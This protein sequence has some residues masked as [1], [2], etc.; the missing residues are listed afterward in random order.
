V[1]QSGQEIRRILARTAQQEVADWTLRLWKI[2]KSARLRSHVCALAV[3]M[4]VP[5]RKRE[6]FTPK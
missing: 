4:T 1:V 5:Q 2:G 3:R 6:G